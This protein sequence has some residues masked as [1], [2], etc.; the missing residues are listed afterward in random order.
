[1]KLQGQGLARFLRT[2]DPAVLAALVYGPDSGLVRERAQALVAAA[3]GDAADPFRVAELTP[4]DLKNDPARLVDEAAALPFTGGRRVVRLRDATDAAA[5]LLKELLQG[6]GQ[7]LVVLEAGELSP[8]S[9][10]RALCEA[11][12]QAAAIACYRDEGEALSGVIAAELK[13][14]G[15]A[16]APDALEYLTA[17]LGGDRALTRRELEKLA[18]YMADSSGAG[19]AGADGKRGATVTLEDAMATVG[20][21]AA[22]GLDDLIHHLA[23]GNRPAIERDLERQLAEGDS[24]V[25]ILRAA[26]RH[27][28]RLHVAVG[29]IARGQDADAAM[30]GLRPP[31]FFRDKD[32]FRKQLRRWKPPALARALARL[33]EAE[34]DCKTTGFPAE[35]ICRR[36]FAEIAQGR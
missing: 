9:P 24:P 10:L 1:V 27:F 22:L 7:G 5:P 17:N 29:A 30:A 3:A 34:I 32:R 26:A 12:N 4:A 19:R 36:V 6:A 11:S 33:T 25:T 31:V 16:A 15:L 28:M 13:R 14:S 8:R 20:D 18:L 35:T 21:T 23:E 2:P